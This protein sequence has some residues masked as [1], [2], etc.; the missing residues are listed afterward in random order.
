MSSLCFGDQCRVLLLPAESRRQPLRRTVGH[1]ELGLRRG[2]DRRRRKSRQPER[3]RIERGMLR[4]PTERLEVHVVVDLECGR[5]DSV[6]L[7][8]RSGE[9][10]VAEFD[11]G[12]HRFVVKPLGLLLGI[13][14][15]CCSRPH[16]LCCFTLRLLDCLLRLA[17][18]SGPLPL[19]L[20][21]LLLPALVCHLRLPIHL[22]Q[23][24]SLLR[25][26]SPPPAAC[27]ASVRP[28]ARH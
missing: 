19:C 6:D 27:A 10:L 9:V 8:I 17:V 21:G 20:T 23:E 4:G 14:D 25:H 26:H 11:L 7:G 12:Q 28:C 1:H 2:N 5:E 15:R 18:S 16:S 13:L 3:S 22:G 24:P